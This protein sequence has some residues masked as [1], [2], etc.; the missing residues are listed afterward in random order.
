MSLFPVLLALVMRSI[1]RPLTRLI[2]TSRKVSAGDLAV[3]PEHP[4]G[5]S[6]IRVVTK[7]FNDMTAT[8]RAYEQQLRRLASGDTR[9]DSHLP[10]PLGDS[11]RRS[12]SHLAEVTSQLHASEAAAVMQART[13][14]LTG[15]NNRAAALEELAVVTM[16][17]RNTDRTGAIVFLDLDGFKAINDTLGHDAGDLLLKMT[18]RRLEKCVREADTVAA[19]LQKEEQFKPWIV[20]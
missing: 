12:V 2:S 14:S 17:A 20:R 8:L 6:D 3:A 5:P 9:I 15:L 13:D 11:L 19:R 1:L 4:T 16:Q 7:A 10:G 18:A